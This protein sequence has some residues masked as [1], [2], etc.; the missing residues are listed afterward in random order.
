M[1]RGA[2]V[3]SN[4]SK[5]VSVNLHLNIPGISKS[6]LTLGIG[7]PMQYS[8]WVSVGQVGSTVRTAQ[9]KFRLVTSLGGTGLLNG[10]TI[11]LPIYAE[12]AYA[13]ARLTD[14]GCLSG[15][16]NANATIATTPGIARLAVADVTDAM[17]TSAQL[18]QSLPPAQLLT[19]AFSSISGSSEVII[20][21]SSPTD[22]NF[23]TSDVEDKKIK[24]AETSSYLTSL[25]T[26]LL[27]KLKPH[28]QVLGLDITTPSLL[29]S[30]V[31]SQLQGIASPLDDA[32][33]EIFDVLGVHLGEADVRVNGI[34][35]GSAALI[36]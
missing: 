34:R 22:L 29:T 10:A 14:V 13:S 1:L 20:G 27:G 11:R 5:Q 35:C 24:R 17:M 36:N 9:L 8:A 4:G 33:A 30:A 3:L 21:N 26:S 19:T 18:S 2:A 31:S 16:Q 32:L 12:A 6:V 28:V 15:S 7:E 25:A 23:S